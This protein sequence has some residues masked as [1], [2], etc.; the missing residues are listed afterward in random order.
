M[1]G[2]SENLLINV[3]NKS[4]KITADVVVPEGGTKGAINVQDGR[5]GR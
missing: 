5:F 3:N 1:T 2:T 4:V